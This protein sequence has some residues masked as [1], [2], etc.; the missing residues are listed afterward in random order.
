MGCPGCG[1]LRGHEA[2]LV[3]GYCQ[4]P[5]T[6]RSE[7]EDIHTTVNRESPQNLRNVKGTRISNRKH[8]Y[9]CKQIHV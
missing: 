7:K 3:K 5:L 4:P 8:A 1:C 9:A 2:Y 6:L